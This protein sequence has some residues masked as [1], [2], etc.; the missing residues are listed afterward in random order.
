MDFT[1]L[2]RG[3]LGAVMTTSLS[4]AVHRSLIDMTVI[5]A[6]GIVPRCFDI[7]A[8]PC[9]AMKSGGTCVGEKSGLKSG[10]EQKN[11]REHRT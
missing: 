1:A 3:R 9:I 7:D 2:V 6:S 4:F 5:M 8:H 10:H 11:D